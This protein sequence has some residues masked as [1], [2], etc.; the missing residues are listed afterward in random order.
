MINTSGMHPQFGMSDRFLASRCRLA[1]GSI[2]G[3]PAKIA[4]VG[5]PG[6]QCAGIHFS[7]SVTLIA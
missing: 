7:G 3:L 1:C 6:Q 5:H 4:S 2:I